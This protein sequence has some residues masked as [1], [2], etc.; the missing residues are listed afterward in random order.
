M[1]FDIIEDDRMAS[2]ILFYSPIILKNAWDKPMIIRNIM[3]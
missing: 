3:Q 1:T 2:K